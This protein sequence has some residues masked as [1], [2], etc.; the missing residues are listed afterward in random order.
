MTVPR[1][2]L[3]RRHTVTQKL[4]CVLF[5]YGNVISLPQSLEARRHQAALTGLEYARFRQLWGQ[6]RPSYDQGVIDGR[7]YWSRICAH[8]R[9]ATDD[10]LLQEL[11]QAD[12]ESWRPVNDW[13]LDWAGRLRDSGIQTGI[14]SNMPPELVADTREMP[15]IGEFAPLYFSAEIREVKP[16]APIY[17]HVID[18]LSCEPSATLFVDDRVDNCRGARRAGLN[19]IAHKNH[20]Q[21]R[22]EVEAAFDIPLP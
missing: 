13:V 18:E 8:S 15:W 14:L 7:T 21:T 4:N 9:K 6:Y 10:G 17:A 2:L 20:E 1:N 3:K 22:I 11:I 19:A 12:I 16:Y 5:D